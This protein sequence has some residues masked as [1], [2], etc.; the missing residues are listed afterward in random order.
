MIWSTLPEV[1]LMEYI[2]FEY[3]SIYVRYS[4]F[5]EYVIWNVLHLRELHREYMLT[6]GICP[7]KCNWEEQFLQQMPSRTVPGSNRK[8]LRS[9]ILLENLH[10]AVFLEAYY[11]YYPFFGGV[12]AGQWITMQLQ[13]YLASISHCSS[14][15]QSLSQLSYSAFSFYCTLNK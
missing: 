4:S 1:L 2:W 10:C 13:G 12:G 14:L 6:S 9:S 8:H 5:L 7:I 11:R 3:C 15:S